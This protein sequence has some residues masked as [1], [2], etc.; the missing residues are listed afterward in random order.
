M[1]MF[2]LGSLLMT[3]AASVRAQAHEALDFGVSQEEEEEEKRVPKLGAGEE[4]PECEPYPQADTWTAVSRA[5][6]SYVVSM[7]RTPS[8][9]DIVRKAECTLTACWGGGFPLP[10]WTDKVDHA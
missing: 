8:E 1:I 9:S 7:I 4:A 10:M 2:L 5:L 6:P 3:C